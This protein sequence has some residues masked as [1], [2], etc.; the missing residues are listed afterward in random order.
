MT[1]NKSNKE[2]LLVLC[3]CSSRHEAD[4]IATA[5][6]EERLAACVNRLPGF[7]SL[8]RWEGRVQRDDEILLLIKTSSN[9]FER[10]E[11][12]IKSLHAYDT[13]EII[14]V[15]IVAGS[16]KYLQWIGESTA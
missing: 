2:Y 5:L 14:G 12:V 4:A 16:A 3:T 10:L 8:F 7:E 1:C 13:P 11:Q 15:P 9:R 6:V